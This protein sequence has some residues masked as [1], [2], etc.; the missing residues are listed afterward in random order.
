MCKV[1]QRKVGQ[2]WDKVKVKLEVE[3]GESLSKVSPEY[4]CKVERKVGQ[5]WDKVK[6]KLGESLAK[7]WPKIR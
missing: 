4:M 7:V 2:S 1:G 6:V 3:L 5:S